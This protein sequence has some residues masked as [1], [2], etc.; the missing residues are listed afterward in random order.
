MRLSKTASGG[1]VLIVGLLLRVPVTTVALPAGDLRYGLY[2]SARTGWS[3]VPAVCFS[4][5]LRGVHV[6][7]YRTDA[8]CAFDMIL[9]PGVEVERLSLSLPGWRLLQVTADSAVWMK[10]DRL[11]V[12]RAPLA[13]QVRGRSV[14][15]LPVGFRRQDEAVGFWVLGYDPHHLLV[16]DPEILHLSYAGDALR[17][18][19]TAVT[20]GPDGSTF[21]AGETTVG[22][23]VD[24]LVIKV[25]P[26]GTN[27][28]YMT[29]ISGSSNDVATGIAVDDSGEVVV[30]GYTASTDFPV[31]NYV[32]GTNA[33]GYDAFL[34]RL[35]G[36]GSNLLFSSYLGGRED[37]FARDVCITPGGTIAVAGY[38]LS[39]DFPL[40][41]AIQT[42]LLG[43]RDAF[44]T[45]YTSNFSSMPFSTYLGGDSREYCF[46]VASRSAGAVAVC[47]YT[48]SSN[49][50][51]TAGAFQTDLVGEADIFV[52]GVSAGVL[53]YSTLVGGSG[54]DMG[55]DIS[56]GTAGELSVVGRTDSADF[57][58][59]GA[60]QS[61]AAGDSEAF[62]LQLAP[63]ATSLWFSS[64]LGGTYA[65]MGLGI[66]ADTDGRLHICGYTRSSDLPVVLPVQ[67]GNAGCYDGFVA[68]VDP[69]EGELLYCTYLGGSLTDRCA[70]V[71]V[72]TNGGV[73]IA[74]FTDSHDLAVTNAF[75]SAYGG[76]GDGLFAWL[77]LYPLPVKFTACSL[78]GTEVRMTWRGARG[79]RF[80]V[81]ESANLQ[82]GEWSV[83]GTNGSLQGMD[84]P[85]GASVG[86]A[87]T[88]N[89]RLVAR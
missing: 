60:F 83:A 74:G 62:I 63:A 1:F 26:S 76:A 43:D 58:V 30:C 9:S 27:I 66:T 8:A 35:D 19:L 12:C 57:P 86:A 71:A 3:P 21:M 13:Y 55:R 24:A 56:C 52:S 59:L 14:V 11:L 39:D 84:G 89:F 47:G 65:D 6:V 20:V 75:Q 28:E 87:E 42:N 38:T 7:A 22:G 67:N 54:T 34:I 49:Y 23:T 18:A 36:S 37:D 82:G 44:V 51:T 78:T 25:S 72:Q 4:D 68:G 53:E 73:V 41:A 10:G 16:I 17:D 81:E 32:Q 79:W 61:D 40:R 64:F 29:V 2:R 88:R 69:G 33:G 80:A 31:I 77:P 5:L 46:G 85:M 48:Y 70:A 15:R 45:M 50:P